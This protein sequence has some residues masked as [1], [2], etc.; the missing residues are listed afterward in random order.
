MDQHTGALA[1]VEPGYYRLDPE[2]SRVEIKMKANWG[3]QRVRA[4]FQIKSGSLRVDAD[5]GLSD[6]SAVIDPA[7]FFSRNKK[8]DQHVKSADFLDAAT[9]RQIS[10]AGTGVR[11]DGADLILSGSLTVH[12]VTESVDVRVVKVTMMEGG[13][14][15]FAASACLDRGRFGVAS[16]PSRIGKDVELS[17]DAVAART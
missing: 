7:T 5:A 10:F 11:A 4:T 1:G 3:L 2:R 14:A 9:Y 13:A 6:V 17:F 15:R 12:G 16:M 8:R